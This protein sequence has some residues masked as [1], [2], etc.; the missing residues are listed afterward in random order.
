M[1]LDEVSL[2]F[3]YNY[4]LFNYPVSFWKH[5]K[6]DLFKKK[7]FEWKKGIFCSK[8]CMNRQRTSS[9]PPQNSNWSNPAFVIIF[10]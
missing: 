8:K 4:V 7:T 10:F 5:K 1:V 9:L 6:Y 3:D 2:F